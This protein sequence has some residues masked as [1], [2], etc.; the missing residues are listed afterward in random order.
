MVQLMDLP[1]EIRLQI[2]E[3]VITGYEGGLPIDQSHSSPEL[4]DAFSLRLADKPLSDDIIP[5]Y[6]SSNTFYY[7]DLF[8]FDDDDYLRRSWDRWLSNSVKGAVRHI[9][10][11]EFYMCIPSEYQCQD[12]LPPPGE[13]PTDCFSTATV[14]LGRRTDSA[15]QLGRDACR[16]AKLAYDRLMTVLSRIPRHNRQPQV[17]SALIMELLECTLNL[18]FTIADGEKVT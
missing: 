14:D 4:R 6:W 5:L 11:L 2:Y 10:R 8:Q 12:T 9:R 17:T 15:V 16:H 18:K 13:T 7:F 1:H 3:A